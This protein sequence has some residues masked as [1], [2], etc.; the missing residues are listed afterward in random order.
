MWCN[1]NWNLC[2]CNVSD[3]FGVIAVESGLTA[4]DMGENNVA[5]LVFRINAVALGLLSLIW[6]NSWFI[7]CYSFCLCCWICEI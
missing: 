2:K 1:Y 3:E 6:C 4:V 7:W 5:Y